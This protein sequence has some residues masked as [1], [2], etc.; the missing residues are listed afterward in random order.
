MVATADLKSAARKGMRVR[1]PPSPLF[2]PYA[3]SEDQKAYHKE[4]YKRNKTKVKAKSKTSNKTAIKRNREF[5][6]N[7]KENTPC[8]DCKIKYH[9]CV[10]NFDHL[11]DK[12]ANLSRL[13]RNS[14]SINAL[15]LEMDKCEL[16]CSNCHR[17]R[18]WKRIFQC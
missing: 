13:V 9:Y 6:Q 15:K 16:V 2:M 17:I 3:N 11:R 5:I 7:Y 4:W 12:K 1:F 8:F 18:T 14:L 10:M